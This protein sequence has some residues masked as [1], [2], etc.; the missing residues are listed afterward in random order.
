M[1]LVP[2][3]GDERWLPPLVDKGEV[4]AADVEEEAVLGAAEAKRRAKSEDGGTMAAVDVRVTRLE[5]PT[6]LV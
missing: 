4:E 6:A 1:M 3:A 2:S 5:D